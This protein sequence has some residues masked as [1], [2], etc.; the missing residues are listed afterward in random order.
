MLKW[1]PVGNAELNIKT[2]L[3]GPVLLK[4]T[5]TKLLARIVP[6][7]AH[8]LTK[9]EFVCKRRY[10]HKNRSEGVG[11]GLTS[12]ELIYTDSLSNPMLLMQ[13]VKFKRS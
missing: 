13:L 3:E 1:S 2:H 11:A 10:M 5:Y 12:Y 4:S 9:T 6:G 7:L 8:D